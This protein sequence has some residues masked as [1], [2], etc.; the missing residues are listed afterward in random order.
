DGLEL[1]G[2]QSEAVQ[3]TGSEPPPH[4]CLVHPEQQRAG[5]TTGIEHAHIRPEQWT[6]VEECPQALRVAHQPDELGIGTEARAEQSL[7]VRGHGHGRPST[8]IHPAAAARLT[9]L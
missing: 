5:P 9:A 6:R 4:H 3:R 8:T 2:V 1:R 7:W